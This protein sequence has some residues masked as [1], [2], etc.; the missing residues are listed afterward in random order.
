MSNLTSEEKD[1]ILSRLTK[2]E[3]NEKL[4]TDRI[5]E[6][7]ECIYDMRRDASNKEQAEWEQRNS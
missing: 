1:N 2:L 4:L 3:E 7:Q 5:E 6:L